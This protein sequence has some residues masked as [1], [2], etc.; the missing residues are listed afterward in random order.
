MAATLG[1][2]VE[3]VEDSVLLAKCNG[4]YK[5]VAEE[6]EKVSYAEASQQVVEN[7]MHGPAYKEGYRSCRN[8]CKIGRS[9]SMYA[10]YVTKHYDMVT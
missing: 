5:E 9:L 2:Q 10:S 4:N 1:H 8:C 3:Q 7:T 6:E